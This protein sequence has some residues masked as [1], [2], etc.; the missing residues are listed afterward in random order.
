MS[1]WGGYGAEIEDTDAPAEEDTMAQYR[2]FV[3]NGYRH[4]TIPY[5]EVL[6][7]GP[8]Q[9]MR[10]IARREDWEGLKWWRG[11]SDGEYHAIDP[12]W[13]FCSAVIRKVT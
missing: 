12:E 13:K 3:L 6:Q 10:E 4:S 9:V 7:G 2:T 8:V 5:R 1:G 11:D